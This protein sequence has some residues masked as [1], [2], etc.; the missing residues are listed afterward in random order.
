MG[1]INPAA[2]TQN[3]LKSVAAS[4]GNLLQLARPV[5]TGFCLAAADL[6]PPGIDTRLICKRSKV[7]NYEPFRLPDRNRRVSGLICQSA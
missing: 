6:N 7:L 5:D 4:V 1:G 2:A 3:R